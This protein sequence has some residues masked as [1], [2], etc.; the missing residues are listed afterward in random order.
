MNSYF[1][2]DWDVHWGYGILIHGHL[3]SA[4]LLVG[5]SDYLT[6]PVPHGGL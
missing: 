1:R 5:R 3:N 6:D 2:G 4:G